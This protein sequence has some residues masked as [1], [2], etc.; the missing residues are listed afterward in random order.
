MTEPIQGALLAVFTTGQPPS[1]AQEIALTARRMLTELAEAATPLIGEAGFRSL[2]ARS[3]H[4]IRR[5]H[6]WLVWTAADPDGFEALETC[7]GG[8][9]PRVA[10]E[11]TLALFGTLTQLLTLFIGESLT[12]PLLRRAWPGVDLLDRPQESPYE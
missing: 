3:A 6:D 11:A 8:Q 10:A 1:D 12:T 9:D 4:L 2:L 5:Q 7:L